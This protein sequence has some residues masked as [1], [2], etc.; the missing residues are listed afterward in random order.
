MKSNK[1]KILIS[2]AIMITGVFVLSFSLTMVINYLYNYNHYE[3]MNG[4]IVG[5]SIG[6]NA[7]K[8][9]IISYEVDREEYKIHSSFED[10]KKYPV[11]SL[12]VVRYNKNSP[13]VYILGNEKLNFGMI[14]I[15]AVCCIVGLSG[16]LVIYSKK[17]KKNTEGEE[18]GK[19]AK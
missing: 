15:G 14:I 10:E 5:Y 12:V 7:E 3:K 4:T 13:D 6:D 1:M 16:M 19:S 18:N 2:A 11:G 17:E 8:N 9:M